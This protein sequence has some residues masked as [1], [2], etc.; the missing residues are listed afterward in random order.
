MVKLYYPVNSVKSAIK[1]LKKSWTRSWY[2]LML[3]LLILSLSNVYLKGYDDRIDSPPITESLPESQGHS[4]TCQCSPRR[5]Q[6]SWS[7][8]QQVWA[9]LAGTWSDTGFI[10]VFLGRDWSIVELSIKKKHWIL[11]GV[12]LDP[13]KIWVQLTNGWMVLGSC[14]LWGQMDLY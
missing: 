7:Q 4:A 8:G 12:A 5:G 2:F 14:S 11:N 6:V 13:S 1:S 3:K 10:I 9:V